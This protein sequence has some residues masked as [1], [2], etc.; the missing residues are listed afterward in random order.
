[1]PTYSDPRFE[2]LN[3]YMPGER[4]YAQ[5]FDPEL[6]KIHAQ[7]IGWVPGEVFITYPVRITDRFTTGQHDV[8]WMPGEAVTRIRRRDSMWVSTEDDY[9]WHTRQDA[10]ITFRAD[11]WTAPHHGTARGQAF[12]LAPEGT[13]RISNMEDRER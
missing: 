9:P 12:E 13:V 8:K 5:V 6:G 11:P 3:R 1:M 7:V 2:D 4:P 10:K